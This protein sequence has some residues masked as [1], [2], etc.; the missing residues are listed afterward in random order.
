MP[1]HVHFEDGREVI[2]IMKTIVHHDFSK[3]MG[4]FEDESLTSLSKHKNCVKSWNF[5]PHLGIVE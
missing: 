3:G 5:K 2:S 1:Q 4:Q